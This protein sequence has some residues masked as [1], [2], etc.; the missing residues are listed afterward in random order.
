M[1]STES[2]KA[3]VKHTKNHG[4][5]VTTSIYCDFLLYNDA[6]KLEYANPRFLMKMQITQTVYVQI[7]ENHKIL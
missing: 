4:Y 1:P 7:L 6:P 2:Y 5:L 3:K